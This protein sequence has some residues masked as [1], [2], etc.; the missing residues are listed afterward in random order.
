MPGLFTPKKDISR[1]ESSIQEGGFYIPFTTP[2]QICKD[3]KPLDRRLASAK[4]RVEDRL[5]LLGSQMNQ[6]KETAR[7]QKER[8]VK[9]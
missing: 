7:K 4:P 9:R 1:Q 5:L 8:S 3:M 2:V 6:K